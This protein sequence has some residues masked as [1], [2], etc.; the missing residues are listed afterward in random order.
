MSDD[1]KAIIFTTEIASND[2][3]NPKMIA[4]EVRDLIKQGLSAEEAAE[5]LGLDLKR[6][7]AL[8]QQLRK[9]IAEVGNVPS[10]V[11]KELVRSARLKLMLKNV[12]SDDTDEQKIALQAAKQIA[13]DPEVGLNQPPQVIALIDMESLGE[14]IKQLPDDDI[15]EADFEEVKDETDA[16]E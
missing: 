1:N 6:N 16:D 14:V 12:H 10:M 4:N 15:L 5:Q 2:M 9:L 11:Q 3:G 13:S 8:R 7:G